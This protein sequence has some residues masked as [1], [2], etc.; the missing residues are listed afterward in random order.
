M[1]ANTSHIVLLG[2]S[3]FDN[4]VYVPGKPSVHQQ[5]EAKIAPRGWRASL[6]AV[7]GNVILDVERQ[8]K[9]LPKDA[10]HLF[11]S[12]G[13]LS[14]PTCALSPRSGGNNGLRYMTHLAAE[15]KTL[16]D[17]LLVMAKLREKFKAD[18][19][20]MI[21][22]LLALK[23][24]TTVCAIYNPRFPAAREQTICETGLCFLNDVIF[25]VAAQVRY[26]AETRRAVTQKAHRVV[27][28][29]LHSRP[30]PS[31]FAAQPARH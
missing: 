11:V 8:L 23:L 9:G 6:L 21:E 14:T 28:Y 19:T 12:V 16:G 30:S 2:D 10:T 29:N 31:L 5:L 20:S 24:P 4:G 17:A 25:G 26:C 3:I 1:Q 18:Y 15:S 22:K 7:D 27:S 13:A